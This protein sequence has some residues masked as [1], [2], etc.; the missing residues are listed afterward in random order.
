[1][2]QIEST[3]PLSITQAI[4]A[5]KQEQPIPLSTTTVIQKALTEFLSQRGYLPPVK[6]RFRIKPANRGSGYTDTSINHDSVFAQS[7]Q[8]CLRY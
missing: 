4:D 8:G 7:S 6:K 5:Y 2:E 1:M 3:L